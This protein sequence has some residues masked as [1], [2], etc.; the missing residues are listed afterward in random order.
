MERGVRGGQPL[1]HPKAPS[2][3]RSS[4]A[5]RLMPFLLPP[6]PSPHSPAQAGPLGSTFHRHQ[7]PYLEGLM[8]QDSGGG[9]AGVS[10]WN[11]PRMQTHR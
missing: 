3:S 9:R 10:G 11:C 5:A 2:P 6:P 8:I 4:R 7:D 1:S